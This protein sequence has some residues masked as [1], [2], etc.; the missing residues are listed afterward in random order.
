MML[1]PCPWC[2]ERPRV[3]FSYGGPD[4]A[5]RP[6]PADDAPLED[7]T[8]YV[9]ERDNPKGAARELWRHAAGCRQWFVIERDTVTHTITASRP[10]PG[11]PEPEAPR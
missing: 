5:D 6:R 4:P 1:I 8:R 9:Y 2:G 10:L 11:V 7:W 3:E